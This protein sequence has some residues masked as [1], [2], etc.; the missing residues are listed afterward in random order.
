MVKRFSLQKV[1]S[2][3]LLVFVLAGCG[4]SQAKT[5]PYVDLDDRQPLP[6]VKPNAQISIRIGVAAIM[7]PEGTADSYDELAR[8][9]EKK[10]GQKVELVQRR[11]YAEINQ[12]VADAQVDL[13]FVCTYAYVVGAEAAQMELLAAPEVGGRSVY[14]ARVIVP[15]NSPARTISSL[16]DKSFAFTDPM[17]FTGR[18]Y[19]LYLLR[20]INELPDDFF[21]RT[22]YTYS[23]DRAIQA[24]AEGVADGASVDSLVLAY[25]FQRDPSLADRVR[26]IHTSQ[27]FGIPPV[28]TPSSLPIRQ[29]A[30]M[31]MILLG[32]D[33]DPQGQ[34]VLRHL[35]IDRFTPPS[36]IAYDGVRRIVQTTGNSP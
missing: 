20:Q 27:S 23:H 1:F 12:L 30:H 35:G 26:V 7:S 15:A 18:I 17:S 33:E 34:E 19:P 24:V 14:H 29:R 16:R 4:T 36:D 6:E 31:A 8:Y 32:M 22:F 3:F 25:A 21:G 11:T 13:A 9:L 2:L 28:V 10:L 5:L